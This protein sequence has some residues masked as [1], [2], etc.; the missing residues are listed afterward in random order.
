[1]RCCTV[2][3]QVEPVPKVFASMLEELRALVGACHQ[4]MVRG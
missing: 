3:W 1:M 4:I 2:T